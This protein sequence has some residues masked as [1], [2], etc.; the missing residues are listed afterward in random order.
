MEE[1]L[2]RGSD[3][4]Q[5]SAAC[6]AKSTPSTTARNSSAQIGWRQLQ[7][8]AR[9]LLS[10]AHLPTRSSGASPRPEPTA[11]ASAPFGSDQTETCT[12]SRFSTPAASSLHKKAV[13]AMLLLLSIDCSPLNKPPPPLPPARPRARPC[14]LTMLCELQAKNAPK[15]WMDSELRRSLGR[16]AADPATAAAGGPKPRGRPPKGA[17]A[18]AR[19][20]AAAAAEAED[21]E[22]ASGEAEDADADDDAEAEQDDELDDGKS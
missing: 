5:T 8:P 17:A 4:T 20:S 22:P 12:P 2:S 9:E 15:E 6:R 1:V 16:D 7:T 18:K 11:A 19:K 14:L 3:P 13:F 10:G 21:E